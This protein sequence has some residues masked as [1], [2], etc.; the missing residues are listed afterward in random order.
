MA[1]ELLET[2]LDDLEQPAGRGSHR[3]QTA[4]RAQIVEFSAETAEAR[5]RW[6]GIFKC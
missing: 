6:D 5:R 3:L 2:E 4:T 1:A